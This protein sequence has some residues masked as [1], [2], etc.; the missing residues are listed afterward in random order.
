MSQSSGK[1]FFKI[2]EGLRAYEVG[3]PN[4]WGRRFHQ[5]LRHSRIFQFTAAIERVGRMPLREMGSRGREWMRR[6]FG[7]HDRAA[8]MVEAYEKV[9]TL[10]GS[11]RP[12]EVA[13]G[14]HSEAASE[15]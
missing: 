3:P 5:E 13:G 9:G 1:F 12:L 14:R 7:W 8:Q 15:R 6:E 4:P 11:R 2:D 10:C